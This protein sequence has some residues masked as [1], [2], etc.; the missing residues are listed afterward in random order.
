MTPT[1]NRRLRRFRL[2]AAIGGVSMALHEWGP[3]A[4]HP[5]ICVHGLTRNGRDFDVL[6]RRLS[7]QGRYVIAPDVPGRGHSDW[8]ADPARY[9]MGT[10]VAAITAFFDK[11]GID[12]VDWVGT[13]M[14]GIMGMV[15]ASLPQAKIRRLVLN[16]VGPF[17]PRA[18]LEQIG[19]YVGLAPAFSSIEEVDA[20]VRT[21]HAGFGPLTDA[22]WRQL[23][24]HSAV[25]NG[26]RYRL[27]YDPAIRV[28]FEKA[29][30]DDVDLWRLYDAIT[31]PT[32]VLRGGNSGLLT[33]PV[34][35]EMTRRGP[36]ARLLVFDGIGHA[37]ALLE[38]D[39]VEAVA[40]FLAD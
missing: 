30:S 35:E 29:V 12:R 22:Q 8:L 18:A 20:Y 16:D 23:A 21:V 38:D 4:P 24:R 17:I 34:A 6:A 13:S 33:A 9:D 10:Y 32:L 11:R 25:R 19:S 26:N 15:L 27:R 37:P 28:A 40:S 1:A 2:P 5:V 3:P 7:A 31:S 39:Q 14:G 36:A